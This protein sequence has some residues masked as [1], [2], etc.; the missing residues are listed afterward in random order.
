MSGCIRIAQEMDLLTGVGRENTY[1]N[2]S[3]HAS[4]SIGLA[5]GIHSLTPPEAPVA[6]SLFG[7]FKQKTS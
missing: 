6:G 5:I 1:Y 7:Y 4:F 3:T 2:R